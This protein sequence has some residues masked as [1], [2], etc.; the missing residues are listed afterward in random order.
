[1]QVRSKNVYV[2]IL[3]FFF[4]LVSAIEAEKLLKVLEISLG[5]VIA[6]QLFR[7][8]TVG[9]LETADFREI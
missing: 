8:S 7:V 3:S 4:F 1:M 9:T 5:L 2:N 6:S